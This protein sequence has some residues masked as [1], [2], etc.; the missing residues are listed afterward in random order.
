MTRARTSML[1]DVKRL[2]NSW[3]CRQRVGLVFFGV[4]RYA[5]REPRSCRAYQA[6]ENSQ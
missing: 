5:Q 1:N 2:R 4:G 3:L 6:Q